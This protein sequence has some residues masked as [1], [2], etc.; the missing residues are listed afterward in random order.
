MQCLFRLRVGAFLLA[1]M[2]KNLPATWEA[3]VQ[4][5]GKKDS[6]GEGNG[7]LLEYS[8]L[9]NPMDRGAWQATVHTVTKSQ[10]R[11]SNGHF[12]FHYCHK[13]CLCFEQTSV[14]FNMTH[15]SQ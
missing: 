12:H 2:V 13:H 14:L 3:Q 10:T 15:P 5:L 11:L 8:W 6:P 4:S 7:Y 9:G 1:Q